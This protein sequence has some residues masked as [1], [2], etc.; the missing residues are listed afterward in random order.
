[1]RVR[2]LL[3][4][5]LV[6][7]VLL[8]ADAPTPPAGWSEY[9]PNDRS[10]SVWLP[11]QGGRRSTRQQTRKIRGVPL[12]I[13][14]V[15]FEAPSGVTF[16]AS[17]LQLPVQLAQAIPLQQRFEIIRDAFV[18]EVNGTVSAEMDIKEGTAPGKDYLI[19]SA[20]VAARVRVFAQGGKLYR[21]SVMG[22]K[23][24]IASREA[25]TFLQSFKL[26]GKTPD[27]PPATTGGQTAQEKPAAPALPGKAGTTGLKW[28]AD[29][30]Q[31]VIPQT[32][33]AGKLLG[34]E[35]TVNEAKLTPIGVLNLSKGRQDAEVSIFL[36][37][38]RG[39]NIDNRTIKVSATDGPGQQT[40]HVHFN[41][42]SAP[43]DQPK[44]GAA[45]RG[46]AMQLEFGT[47]KMGIIPAKIYLCLPDQDRSVIAG[48]FNVKR[49]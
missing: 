10:F 7:P 16:G 6:V 8:G 26:V 21:A 34:G 17:T 9:S 27:A 23:E 35:F 13:N 45:V 36:R 37:I 30:T 42:L 38:R 41:N 22:T 31:M 18:S 14:V 44:S 47:E 5:L 2:P 39:E 46:Y 19:E 1:M 15:Q 29:P 48:T 3:V 24:Q 4:G 20:K 32:T 11:A 49:D 33:A 25:D 12:K 43:G 40:P 28:V